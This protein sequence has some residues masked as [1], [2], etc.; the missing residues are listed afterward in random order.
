MALVKRHFESGLRIHAY[1]ITKNGQLLYEINLSDE[2][3]KLTKLPEYISIDND[4]NFLCASDPEKIVIWNANSGKFIRSISIPAHYDFRD[5]KVESS[6]QYAWK[7]HTA[8]AF[9]ENGIIIIPSQRN[10][11]IAADLMLFW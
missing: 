7:G 5:D 3:F 2:S 6:D 8:F 1:D 10:F 9:A 4:G 11:P